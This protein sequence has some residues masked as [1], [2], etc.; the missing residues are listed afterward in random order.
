MRKLILLLLTFLSLTVWAKNSKPEPAP[1][2]VIQEKECKNCKKEPVKAVSKKEDHPKNDH[3]LNKH[4]PVTHYGHGPYKMDHQHIKHFVKNI[5]KEIFKFI[6]H[7]REDETNSAPISR[8]SFIPQEPLVG[9][10]IT[11]TSQSTD[12]KQVAAYEWIVSDGRILYGQT[13]GL[14]FSQPGSY[15]IIHRVRDAAGLE[16]ES[17]AQI[18]VIQTNTPPVAYIA[19]SV[20]GASPFD[21]TLDA[22]NSRDN[23]E[24]VSYEWFYGDKLISSSAENRFVYKVFEEK[25]YNFKLVI[26]DNEGLTS[27]KSI[28][29]DVAKPLPPEGIYISGVDYIDVDPLVPYDEYHFY[30]KKNTNGLVQLLEDINLKLEEAHPNIKLDGN[31]LLV[32]KV[33]TEFPE[34]I[35]ISATVEGVIY[36][37]LVKIFLVKPKLIA[38]I[39]QGEIETY[40]INNPESLFDKAIINFK[41]KISINEEVEIYESRL[42]GG[43]ASLNLTYENSEKYLEYEIGNVSSSFALGIDTSKASKG[44][45]QEIVDE[46]LIM[47]PQS[48]YTSCSF[49]PTV[50]YVAPSDTLDLVKKEGGNFPVFY[51]KYKHSEAPDQILINESR[52]TNIIENNLTS[53]EGVTFI[54]TNERDS[55]YGYVYPFYR[56]MIWINLGSELFNN[57]DSTIIGTLIHEK[58]HVIQFNKLGCNENKIANPL[59]LTFLESHAEY[60]TILG[61]NSPLLFSST[62]YAKETIYDL[63]VDYLLL[64]QMLFKNTGLSSISLNEY[65]MGHIWDHLSFDTFVQ[66]VASSP[67]RSP[68]TYVS[69]DAV[70][71]LG[72]SEYFNFIH[73]L[74]I[75]TH[76]PMVFSYSNF[77]SN[78][79]S[80]DHSLPESFYY[81][82]SGELSTVQK[83]DRLGPFE[84][85]LNVIDWNL[86]TAGMDNLTKEKVRY[87]LLVFPSED[88]NEVEGFQNVYVALSGKDGK[89]KEILWQGN[90]SEPRNFEFFI[91]FDRLGTESLKQAQLVISNGSQNSLPIYTTV[92]PEVKKELCYTG[93]DYLSVIFVTKGE[94]QLADYSQHVIRDT[95]PSG[96][97]KDF[98]LVHGENYFYELLVSTDHPAVG[99]I[100]NW[101]QEKF[102]KTGDG[103]VYD[104]QVDPNPMQVVGSLRRYP[105]PG[106]FYINLTWHPISQDKILIY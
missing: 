94:G 5:F 28:L 2:N 82:P 56:N 68:S 73:N 66:K 65:R 3:H 84:N 47:S 10:V 36:R 92:I 58:Q 91:D 21:I 31:R 43:K 39:P 103:F 99:V 76:Y 8:F 63:K 60:E 18:V 16:G 4:S 30:V 55:A 41:E 51:Y 46:Y 75:S 14:V 57:S 26:R 100:G 90:G 6:K 104:Y 19:S 24:I 23:G 25:S 83:V 50:Y 81:L 102:D 77:V 48:K 89:E 97:C 85:K 106:G 67:I 33:E 53:F 93:P 59:R 101:D 78:L 69:S 15:S 37:K 7:C 49:V 72:R 87:K 35:L 34:T 61:S 79:Y 95:I 22:S 9:D 42:S 105:S 27:T 29:V 12:D 71:Y 70:S 40:A 54:L 64:I 44:L 32:N 11:L 62:E 20:S 80:Y 1:K 17:S 96:S 52:I 98:Y 13:A 74:L 88:E 38:T 86:L 45:R